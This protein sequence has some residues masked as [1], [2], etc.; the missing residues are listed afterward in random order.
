[1]RLLPGARAITPARH[2]RMPYRVFLA[3]LGERLR[4]TYE[5]RASGYESARQ[6]RD[7]VSLIAASL[8]ANK[9][10]NAGLFYVER[11]LRRIDTFGFPLATLDVRQHASVLHQA[12]ARGFDDPLWLGRSSRERRDR[13][14]QALEKDRGPVA[15]LDALGKRNLAVFDAIMQG[16]H[17][18]GPDAIGYFIVSGAS[19]ADDVLAALLLA[20]WAA[21][22]DK[23]TGEVA[24]DLAP[25]FE[26]A[27]ALATCGRTLQ[28]LLADPLYRRHLDARGRRQ[29]V[30]IGYSHR[31]K[32]I[33]PSAPRLLSHQAQHHLAQARPPPRHA[34]GLF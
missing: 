12:V 33:G 8:K 9:G 31:N 6:F 20:R 10:A 2:D 30:L 24:L 14:A 18:Y 17:R 25:Q 13:L 4:S 28:E 16:R 21:A 15:E 22:Y 7:D 26:T 34:A 3:Q 29:C 19:G 5:G 32:Q 1:M 11:L 23:R 27:E